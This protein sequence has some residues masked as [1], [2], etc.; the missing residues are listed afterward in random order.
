MSR[1]VV[2]FLSGA[3]AVLL[4]IALLVF[5]D[6]FGEAFDRV[7]LQQE[8][9]AVGNVEFDIVW[10]DSRADIS[11]APTEAVRM[12]ERYFKCFYSAW[13]DKEADCEKVL[14]ELYADSCTDCL[15][16][17]GALA[18]CASRLK[19]SAIDLTAESTRL[20]LW[21]D[22][23]VEI[24]KDGYILTVRQSSETVFK[25]LKG[26]LSGEGIYTH[27]FIF[28]RYNGVWFITSHQC[29]GGVW[30]Y[31]RQAL[32][33]LCGQSAPSYGMLYDGLKLFRARLGQ[34]AEEISGVITAKGYG[35][36]P[37]ADIRYNREG[38]VEY[39][40][41]WAS[42]V[43]ETRNTAQ[44]SDYDNDSGNFVSQCIYSGVG[45]MDTEGIYIWKWFGERVNYDIPDKGCSMSWTTPDN[46][47][48]YCRGHERTGLITYTGISGGQLEKG[49][50]VQLM[51]GESAFAQV[52]VTDTVTDRSGNKLDFLVTGHD[53]D[54]VNYPLSL[55][56]CDGIRLIKIIGFTE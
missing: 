53:S 24:N 13:G 54:L 46:F 5:F 45:K 30:Y 51:L 10:R 40:F 28:E 52:I 2:F 1:R 56:N 23:I 39:A 26:I 27:T 16:D 36:F 9:S 25:S 20:H 48:L 55:L 15:Y 35:S 14:T 18:S 38:A 22:N 29:E 21:A 42:A 7:F 47:W 49:D 8:G 44:W 31:S 33:A 41:R 32:N 43:R 11:A 12:T 19:G 34:T 3:V 6:P 50:V 37:E 17:L 4:V